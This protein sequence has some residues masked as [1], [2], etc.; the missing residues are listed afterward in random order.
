MKVTRSILTLIAGAVIGITLVLSCSDSSPK[1]VDAGD[2]ATCSCP[3]AESP[4][5]NRVVEKTNFLTVPANTIEQ[6]TSVSCPLDAVV[7]SGG[8]GALEGQEPNIIVEQS[9]P[10]GIGWVCSWRNPSTNVD[11]IVRAIVRCLMP[12]Q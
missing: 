6:S 9:Y 4:I 10:D 5:A 8:C 11:V 1:R 2:A 12:A 3:P 7:L